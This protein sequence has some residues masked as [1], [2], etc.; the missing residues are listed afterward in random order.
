MS[1]KDI[2]RGMSSS[3]WGIINFN[4]CGGIEVTDLIVDVPRRKAAVAAGIGLLLMSIL[5][6]IANFAFIHGPIVPGDAAQTA[7]NILASQS[8]FRMGVGFLLFVAILDV[9]VAW[10]LYVLLKPVNKSLSLLTAWFRVV[11]AAMFGGALVPLMNVIQLLTGAE[12]S[13]M[14]E[15]DQLYA[16]V[17]L[18]LDA[19]DAGWNIAL[20]VFGLHLLLLGYLAFKSGFMPKILGVLLILAALGYLI[21]SLGKILLP[22]YNLTIAAFTFIGEVMLL[23]WLFIKG[24]RLP[25]GD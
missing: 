5:A 15:T 24:S 20:V 16:Q 19:F 7:D 9:V 23:F 17:M 14:F 8:Q 1:K 12:Y 13:A 18:L 11:Y 3:R 6:P 4:E 10:G 21:D 25:E 22:D 2:K